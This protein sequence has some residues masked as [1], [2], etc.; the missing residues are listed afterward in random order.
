M[1][2]AGQDHAPGETTVP[3]PPDKGHTPGCPRRGP[4]EK[5]GAQCHQLGPKG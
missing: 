1:A 3:S 4:H 2:T 5:L